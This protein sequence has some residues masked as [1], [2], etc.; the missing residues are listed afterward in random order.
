M[1]LDY[2]L[3]LKRMFTRAL[4]NACKTLPLAATF[5][6][7]DGRTCVLGIALSTYISTGFRSCGST[8]LR[9]NQHILAHIYGILNLSIY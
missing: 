8:D 4:R 3:I 1:K 5:G 2:S 7:S 9:V 6:I